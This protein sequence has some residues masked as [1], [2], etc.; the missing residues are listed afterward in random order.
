LLLEA[1]SGKGTLLL[2]FNWFEDEAKSALGDFKLLSAFSV[3][4]AA[5]GLFNLT[6]RLDQHAQGSFHAVLLCFNCFRPVIAEN[7]F[8]REI[9]ALL[10]FPAK[11]AK[12][13]G[14]NNIYLIATKVQ[15]ASLPTR[16]QKLL[17]SMTLIDY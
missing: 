1:C 4:F 5:F 11:R 16:E 7:T 15:L 2:A 10:I 8:L 12:N 3:V 14:R 6:V 13:Y 17:S 9:F